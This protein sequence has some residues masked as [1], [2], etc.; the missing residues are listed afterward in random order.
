MLIENFYLLNDYL[1]IMLREFLGVVCLVDDLSH[2][3]HLTL[4]VAYRHGKY[5]VSLVSSPQVYLAVE[6]GVLKQ[7]TR[8]CHTVVTLTL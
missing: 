6:P 1:N 3:D 5:Q 8:S 7:R 2:P 4:V